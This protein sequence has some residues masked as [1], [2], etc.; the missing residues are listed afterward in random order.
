MKDFAYFGSAVE[1]IRATVNDIIKRFPGGL[2]YYENAPEIK[3]DGKTYYL[4]SNECQIDCWSQNVESIP[5]NKNPLRYL[6][7]EGFHRNVLFL[8]TYRMEL[9][10]HLFLGF[11]R[12]R[13]VERF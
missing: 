4:V 9:L 8:Q 3:V 10:Y 1:L 2:C 13:L 7:F 11:Q 12:I 5:D 6:S